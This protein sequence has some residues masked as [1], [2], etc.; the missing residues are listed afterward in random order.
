[1]RR[2]IVLLSVLVLA[3]VACGDDDTSIVS[4]GTSTT[5]TEG[6]DTSGDETTTTETTPTTSPRPAYTGGFEVDHETGNVTIDAYGEFLAEHGLPE[7]GVEAAALELLADIDAEASVSQIAADGGRTLV[8]VEY[9]DLGDDSVAAER[10][11]IVFVGDGDDVFV[12]SG[13][14][15]SRCHEGRGHQDFQ[16]AH[17]L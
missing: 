2:M 6:T 1:M 13:S 10:Y 16:V 5:T 15:A 3:L 12:E 9:A 4:D 7:G 8:T 11:E 14:W 17:C